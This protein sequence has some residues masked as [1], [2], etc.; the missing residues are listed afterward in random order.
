MHARSTLSSVTWDTHIF[1]SEGHGGMIAHCNKGCLAIKGTSQTIFLSCR[2]SRCACTA[3]AMILDS[4]SM[5][6]VR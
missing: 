3:G 5:G 4:M 6:Y 2:L 1:K